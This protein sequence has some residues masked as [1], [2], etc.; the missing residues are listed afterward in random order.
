MRRYIPLVVLVAAAVVLL[1]ALVA[2]KKKVDAGPLGS[3]DHW[4]GGETA[5][6]TVE[7]GRAIE[8]LDPEDNRNTARAGE[9]LLKAGQTAEA[10][11]LFDKALKLAADDDEM[12]GIIALAYRDAQMWDKV[13]EYYAKATKLD[14]ADLDHVAEWGVAYWR[15][16]DKA[17]AVEMFSRVLTAEPDT[18]R[19]YYKIGKGISR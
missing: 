18:L 9:L 19:I 1:P 2:A 11:K 8:R 6:M 15:R 17:R 3:A 7:V 5:A 12:M 14:P 4:K 13:D 10:E 16:G